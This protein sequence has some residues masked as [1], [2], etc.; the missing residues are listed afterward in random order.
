LT[1]RFVVFAADFAAFFTVRT[2]RETTDFFFALLAIVISRLSTWIF[3]LSSMLSFQPSFSE[4]FSA[5]IFFARLT[6]FF[7]VFLGA[8]IALAATLAALLTGRGVLSPVAFVTL[9]D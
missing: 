7:A 2:E 9:C 8:L 5:P 4:P 3:W 1:A 6:N